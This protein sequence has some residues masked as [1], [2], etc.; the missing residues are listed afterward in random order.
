MRLSIYLD[1]NTMILVRWFSGDKQEINNATPC[2]MRPAAGSFMHAPLTQLQ[3]HSR[4]MPGMSFPEPVT[5]PRID[6]TLSNTS[7]L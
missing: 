6:G 3:R 4:T 5:S 1:A 2:P 7:S